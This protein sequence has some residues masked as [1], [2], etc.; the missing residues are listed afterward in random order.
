MESINN[1]LF[2]PSSILVALVTVAILINKAWPRVTRSKQ[3]NKVAGYTSDPTSTQ[4]LS[5]SKETEIPEGWMTD[6]AIFE[7]ERRGLFSQ[8]ILIVENLRNTSNG[9]FRHGCTLLT[10]RNSPSLACTNHLTWLAFQSL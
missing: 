7:L 5:V 6:S 3:N 8:V 1:I 9:R 2:S 4:G 10:V